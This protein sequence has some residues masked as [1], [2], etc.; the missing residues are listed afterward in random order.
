MLTE[1]H[2]F[3][4]G[5]GTGPMRAQPYLTNMDIT[6]QT[7]TVDSAAVVGTEREGNAMG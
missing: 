6:V 4:I 3:N 7:L 5:I 2:F 1:I